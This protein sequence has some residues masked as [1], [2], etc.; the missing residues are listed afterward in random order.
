MKVLKRAI[1]SKV[2]FMRKTVLFL[3]FLVL[4]ASPLESEAKKHPKPPS[5]SEL[6]AG[7]SSEMSFWERI[8]PP[9]DISTN[10]H[11][12]DELF[13]YTTTMNVIFF[14]LVCIGLFGFSW[15]YWH[16]RHPV[17]YYTHG[18]TKLQKTVALVIGLLVFFAIDLNITR[19]SNNDYMNVFSNWPDEKNE[20]VFR[21][22][23]MAQQWAWNFRLPGKDGLFNTVDDIVTVN[24]LHV[25]AGR[26]VVI[27]M[28]SK[29]VLHSLFITN[30][31][32]KVDAI[33]GRITRLWFEVNKPGDYQIACAEMCG[34]SHYQ[35][36]SF[37]TVH[38]PESFR[39]WEN[40]ATEVALA[41]NDPENPELFWGWQWE[42]TKNTIDELP[43]AP[44]TAFNE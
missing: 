10:G 22:E 1:G 24:H 42:K 29:D 35:M 30:I 33:P 17:P 39:R 37:F 7:P 27:Q 5:Y 31:R 14:L 16:K 3:F 26:K 9:E 6:L 11:L 32:R 8:S 15:A 38:T 43:V 41:A 34:T 28:I 13:W 4:S 18:N 19:M 44:K 23:V 36:A 21:V 12:I 20:D 2:F 25:P 40:Q